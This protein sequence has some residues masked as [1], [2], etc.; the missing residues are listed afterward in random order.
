MYTTAS[1]PHLLAVVVVATADITQSRHSCLLTT[2]FTFIM[3][4]KKGFRVRISWTWVE[5]RIPSQVVNGPTLQSS[6]LKLK[7]PSP[8][9]IIFIYESTA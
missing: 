1:R 2:S 6:F 3:G 5:H 4:A 8:A 9:S 7:T